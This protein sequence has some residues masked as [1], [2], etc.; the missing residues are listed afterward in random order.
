MR[1]VSGFFFASLYFFMS[2][3]ISFA[4]KP[5][6]T[7]LSANLRSV[8]H[9][10]SEGGT[11]DLRI[12]L[13]DFVSLGLKN[14][15]WKKFSDTEWIYRVTKI[16]SSSPKTLELRFAKVTDARMKKRFEND[17]ILFR[18]TVNNSEL[19]PRQISVIASEIA[20]NVFP[21][22]ERGKLSIAKDQEKLRAEKETQSGSSGG[23]S[24]QLAESIKQQKIKAENDRKLLEEK[25][26]TEASKKNLMEQIE[27]Q[28]ISHDGPNSFDG[29]F[30]ISKSHDNEKIISGYRSLAGMKCELK[31]IVVKNFTYDT[32]MQINNLINV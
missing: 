17:V 31:N 12:T 6:E 7:F 8:Y 25:L 27:G 29:K 4:S 2:V 11:E 30:V 28:F 19:T 3:C 15:V 20:S 18:I 1:S 24:D 21:M 26:A 23:L 14:G 9:G 5:D 32:V 10:I 16:E 13:S 22:T